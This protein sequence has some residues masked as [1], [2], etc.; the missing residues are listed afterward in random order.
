M[1]MFIYILTAAAV[2]A[3]CYVKR[4]GFR[5]AWYILR[6]GAENPDWDKLGADYFVAPWERKRMNRSPQKNEHDT[7]GASE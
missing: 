2:I 1:L 7:Q 6:T 4:H 5:R 3:L